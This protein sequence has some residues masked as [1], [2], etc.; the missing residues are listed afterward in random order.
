[1]NFWINIWEWLHQITRYFHTRNSENLIL[2]SLIDQCACSTKSSVW[3]NDTKA[4]HAVL[5]WLSTAPDGEI[6]TVKLMF[7]KI[8]H[9]QKGELS[10]Q[11]HT[12]MF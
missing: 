8:Y 4:H 6:Q 2:G 5:G 1:M 11:N 10:N 3:Q 7:G 9:L 12:F